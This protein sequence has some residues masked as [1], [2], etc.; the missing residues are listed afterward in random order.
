M[1]SMP[2]ARRSIA[3]QFVAVLAAVLIALGGIAH[4][5]ARRSLLRAAVLAERGQWA[6]AE[7]AADRTLRRDP[8]LGMAWYYR[9]VGRA[10]QGRTDEGRA[11]LERA[12]SLAHNPAVPRLTLGEILAGRG[13]Y[14]EA[15]PVLE[16]A[17]L[18]NPRPRA[19]AAHYWAI[20]AECRRRAGATPALAAS[21]LWMAVLAGDY[22]SA[23]L[24]RLVDACR[25]AAPGAPWLASALALHLRRIRE[26]APAEPTP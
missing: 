15:L 6:E 11:D 21:A 10:G 17:L 20:L 23:L 16:A 9:G 25:V 8:S 14:A 5:Q 18:M 4:F 22:P 24:A 19:G 2:A 1:L 7:S 26:R 13:R 3:L 12:A